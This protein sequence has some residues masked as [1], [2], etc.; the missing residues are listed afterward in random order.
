MKT[1]LFPEADNTETH[2]QS[3]ILPRNEGQIVIWL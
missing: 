2:L 1:Q 3:K